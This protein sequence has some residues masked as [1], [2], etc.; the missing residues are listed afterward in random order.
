MSSSDILGST[1]ND[2][3]SE[4]FFVISK[5]SFQAFTNSSGFK[6]LSNLI[7]LLTNCNIYTITRADE[8]EPERQEVIKVAKFYEMVHDKRIIGMPVRKLTNNDYV[9]NEQQLIEK[10]P[11]I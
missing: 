10:W 7:T 6:E 2:C 3:Y 8:N 11:L 5:D 4:S 9:P 1:P